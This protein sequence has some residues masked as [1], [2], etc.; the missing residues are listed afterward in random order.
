MRLSEWQRKVIRE[1]VIQIFGETAKVWLFGSRVDNLKR[2]GDI[3][4][5]IETDNQ[6]VSKLVQAEIKLSTQLQLK[7]GEQR[8]NILID[9]PTRLN[10]PPIFEIAKQ[11][12]ILL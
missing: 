1:T 6:D 2:G 10:R 4:L 9:Y 7:L 5:L 11:T 8:I 12:G 3:D